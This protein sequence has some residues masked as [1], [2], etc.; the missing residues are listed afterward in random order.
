VGPQWVGRFDSLYFAPDNPWMWVTDRLHRPGIVRTNERLDRVLGEAGALY[1]STYYHEWMRPQGFHFT[2]GNTLLAQGD[3]VANIT[4]MR[5][6]DMGTFGDAEV[7]AFERLSRHMTRALQMAVRLESLEGGPVGTA[8]LDALAQ[9]LALVDAQQRLQYANAAME[10]LLRRRQGLA[11]RQ[12]LL[13]APHAPLQREL[14]ARVAQAIDL[15]TDRAPADPPLWLPAGPH[16]GV[17][18]QVLPVVGRLGRYLPTPRAALLMVVAPAAAPPLVVAALRTMYGCTPAEARLALA[19]AEGKP[20]RAAAAEMAITYG[21]ARAY[22]K[23]VFS[24]LGVH[25]QAQL[26]VQVLQ[27]RG[28]EPGH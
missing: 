24:K 1:T 20:L 25:S 5:P 19:I 4:L 23:T 18:L 11:L 14:A 10:A 21:S 27:L 6:R 7:G 26:V 13:V 28:A 8:T 15:A 3:I 9:P 2:I 22:L 12:G 16:A 17:A